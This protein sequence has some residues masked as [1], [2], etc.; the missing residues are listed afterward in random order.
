[1]SQTPLLGQDVD[2]GDSINYIGRNGDPVRI[3]AHVSGTS[4]GKGKGK[5]K[6][7]DEEGVVE[8]IIYR[9]S[10]C[11]RMPDIANSR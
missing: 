9:V 6:A 3:E 8:G 11:I 7:E 2:R 5:K 1:V 4:T 10:H